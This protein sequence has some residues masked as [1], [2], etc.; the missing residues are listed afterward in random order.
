MKK[1]TLEINGMMCGMCEKHVNKAILEAFDVKEVHSSY[2][3]KETIIISEQALDADRLRTV[4][5]EAGYELLS[6]SV[7]EYT[8]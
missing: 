5:A 2:E 6:I 4:I 3:S 1:T 7:N 8:E